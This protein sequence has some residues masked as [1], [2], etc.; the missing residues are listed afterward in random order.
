MATWKGSY[1]GSVSDGKEVPR[2]EGVA[3]MIRADY[4]DRLLALNDNDFCF[5]LRLANTEE[6]V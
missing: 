2:L 5:V 6:R 1:Y 3:V 4:Y